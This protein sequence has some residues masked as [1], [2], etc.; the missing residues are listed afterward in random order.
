MRAKL[1][2]LLGLVFLGSL[3]VRAQTATSNE[4]GAPEVTAYHLSAHSF[5]EALTRAA[6]DLKIPMGIS[7]VDRPSL[8]VNLSWNG[9]TP[10]RV[11]RD[12][13]ESQAGYDVSVSDGV[14]HV[15]STEISPE[16]N[17]LLLRIDEFNVPSEAAP[18]A[19]LDLQ[20]LVR[21]TI[22]RPTS[23]G[24][25]SAG[26]LASNT[27][28]P[29]INLQFRRSTVADILDALAKSSLDKIW[30][31]TFEDSFILTSG[32]FRRTNSLWSDSPVPDGQQPIWD[33]LR[34]GQAFPVKQL[35][36]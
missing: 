4:T 26:S 21:R 19:K 20:Q 25:G 15:F 23:Q 10:E 9:A 3:A 7:W 22:T 12:I 1:V 2:I 27:D 32:G 6:S 13:A 30:I 14:V 29:I 28:E 16:Q 8:P 34:W 36:R 33:T 5:I 18:L 24:G 11:I 35:G 17:F 31:A